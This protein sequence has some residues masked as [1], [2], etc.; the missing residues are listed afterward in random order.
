[1]LL[2]KPKFAVF[3]TLSFDISQTE[4]APGNSLSRP[5]KVLK[6]SK[7]DQKCD[8]F[9]SRGTSCHVILHPRHI[10]VTKTEPRAFVRMRK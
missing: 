1:M 8:F 10:R 3:F 6:F 9:N 2:G 4:E 5:D 7:K